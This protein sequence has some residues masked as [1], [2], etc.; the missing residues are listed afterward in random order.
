VA[1]LTVPDNLRSGVTKAHRYEPF[2]NATYQ[3]MAEHYGTAILPARLRKSKD[4]AKVEGSVLIVSRWILAALRNHRFTSIDEANVVVA[5][6]LERV[7]KIEV[8]EDLG[9]VRPE[10]REVRM[11]H[12]VLD[13]PQR[14]VVGSRVSEE[15][16]VRRR[17][18]SVILEIPECEGRERD[19][20][21]DND[22]LH[23]AS[24]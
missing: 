5:Q 3:E 13:S 7:T 11:V 12:P 2:V 22:G 4:K 8:E 20:Q 17:Q 9:H 16:R 1:E 15:H 6:L 18:D 10:P 24:N 19:D 23:Q 14:H 21:Q